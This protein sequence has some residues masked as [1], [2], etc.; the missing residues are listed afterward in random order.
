MT[1]ELIFDDEASI[2]LLNLQSKFVYDRKVK[3]AAEDCARILRKID[4]KDMT[5]MGI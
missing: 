1:L 2:G 3:L 5:L 4:K